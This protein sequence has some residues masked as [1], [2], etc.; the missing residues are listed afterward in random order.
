MTHQPQSEMVE[1][2]HLLDLPEQDRLRLEEIVVEHLVDRAFYVQTSGAYLEDGEDPVAHFCRIG[3]R[4][5]LKPNP[6]FDV[7]WYWTNHLDPSSA[8]INPLVHYALSGQQAGVSTHPTPRQRP[9][10]ESLPS[11]R[12]P[13]RA[14]LFAAFDAEGTVDEATRLLIAELD[15]HCDVFVLYDN[16]MSPDELAK[17]ADITVGAWAVRHGAYDFGSYSML[18]RDL[19]GWDRLAAYDEVLFVNDSCFL[20]RPLD[21]VFGQMDR[22]NCDWWGLQATKGLASTKDQVSNSFTEP[23]PI[24]RVRAEMLEG[25][26]HD[27]V[28]DFHIG[29]YFLAFRRPVLEDPGFRRL[30][31]SV[32]PAGNK[33]L[34]ILKYEVGITHLLLGHGFTFDTFMPSLDPF[35]PLFTLRHFA[36]LEQGFPLLKR[37]LIYQ[38]HYD[39][40]G[41]DQWHELVRA[42]CAEAPVDVFES[43]LQR[44]APDDRLQ[45]SMSIHADADGRVKVPRVLRG[46]AYRRRDAAVD[47]NSDTWVFAVDVSDHRLPPNSRAIFEAVKDDPSI[48]KVVLTRSKR[49]HL[50]GVNVVTEPL[51]SPRGRQLLLRAGTLFLNRRPRATFRAPLDPERQTIVAVRD[52]LLLERTGRTA[53]KPL[54][55]ETTNSE[56]NELIHPAPLPAYSGLLVASDVDALAAVA[57]HWPATYS[58]SWRTGIPAHDFLFCAPEALPADMREELQR[59]R[60]QVAGRTLVLF[61]PSLRRT[62]ADYE[63]YRFSN[64]EIAWLRSWTERDDIALGIREHPLDLERPYMTQLGEFALDLSVRHYPSDHVVLR[65]A[66]ALMTDFSGSALDFAVTGKPVLS[67]AHDLE[68]AQDRLLYDLEHFFPGPVAC[69]FDSLAVDLEYLPT[70]QRSPRY[71]RIREMLTDYHDAQNTNRVLARLTSTAGERG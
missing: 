35:H 31:D 19:V 60:A 12:A 18:A 71:D 42:A 63:P 54:A 62:G 11:D 34:V 25:F 13:R 7:W 47:K 44:T 43:S 27:P 45:R 26:E 6:T 14:C 29:S 58:Q 50:D 48:T 24:E 66:D 46:N 9:D 8:E 41:L 1:L 33:L 23:I 55:P 22:R 32:G 67:F 5:L 57:S 68:V 37:Y 49:I 10:A 65:A 39:V 3:W 64:A 56:P 61:A 36:L 38:N 52:G 70:Q 51:L 21:A 30:I 4:L 59:L 53:G 20:V 2:D 40:P 28:Y 69:T 15:R 17:L 16:Y